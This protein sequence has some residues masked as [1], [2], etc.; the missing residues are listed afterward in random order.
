MSRV[1]AVLLSGVALL[2]LTGCTPG[3]AAVQPNEQVA[4]EDRTEEGPAQGGAPAAPAGPVVAFAAGQQIAWDTTPTAPVPA[5]P[6]T[7]SLTCEGLEHNVTLTGGGFE[8]EV[9]VVCEE[10][11]TFSSDPLELQPGTYEY[12]CTIP[13]HAANMTGEMTVQ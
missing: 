2:A 12:V 6:A 3:V 9:V 5:G 8:D 11:G 7:V 4:A 10:A 13:G 1:A